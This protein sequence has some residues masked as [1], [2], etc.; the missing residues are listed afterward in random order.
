VLHLG[1][2]FS[3][4]QVDGSSTVKF[5][6]RPEAHLSDVK[7]ANTGSFAANSYDSFGFETALV[8]GPFSAQAEYVLTSVDT[9]DQGGNSTVNGWYVYGSWFPTGESR[10]YESSKGVF[11]RVHPN[12]N[13]LQGGLG[14]VELALRFS[15]LDLNDFSIIPTTITTSR[16]TTPSSGTVRGLAGGKATDITAGVNWY[17]NP[18]LRVMLNYVH[19]NIDDPFTSL[20][21]VDV[22]QTRFQVDF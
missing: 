18:N 1:T 22:F 8:S 19:S 7:A 21:S 13:F 14:A 5:A 10:H 9:K 4:R 2:A 16:A 15:Q 3:H 17:L 6:E 20:G 12:S 11:G